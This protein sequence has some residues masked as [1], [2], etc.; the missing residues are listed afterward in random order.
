MEEGDYVSLL[1][2][3][4]VFIKVGNERVGM[5]VVVVGCFIFYL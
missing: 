2:V 4:R 1:N 5:C 3:F